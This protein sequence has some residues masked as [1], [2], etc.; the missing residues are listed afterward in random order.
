MEEEVREANAERMSDSEKFSEIGTEREYRYNDNFFKVEQPPNSKEEELYE[1]TEWEEEEIPP[2]LDWEKEAK[3]KISITFEIKEIDD[4][5]TERQ[6]RRRQTIHDLPSY[7]PSGPLA[8]DILKFDM[9]TAEPR[10]KIRYSVSLGVPGI[11]RID[12]SPLTQKIVGCIVGK[13]VTTE[14]P[15]VHV[16]KEVI[17]DNIDLHSESSDFLPVKDEIHAF[18]DEKILIGYAPSLSEKGQF[19][20]V[21]TE[22]GRDIVE[23]YIKMQWEEYADRVKSTIYKILGQW[24]DLGSGA[25]IDDNIVKNTR[26]LFEIEVTSTADLLNAPINLTDRKADDQTN[27]YIELLPSSQQIFE[28]VW[29]KLVSRY[30]QVTPIVQHNEAQ[31]APSIPVNSGYQY[32]YEYETDDLSTYTRERIRSLKDFLKRY[33]NKI[34]DQVLMNSVWDIYTNDYE[35]LVRNAKDTQ[36]PVPIGYEEHQSYYRKIIVDKVINDLCWHPFWTGTAIATYTQHAKGEHLIGPK[37]YDEVFLA[38]NGKNHVLIWSFTD[39]L[40]PKLILECPREVTSVAVCP[41]DATIIVGGCIN[42]Q[43][44]IWHIP[45]KIE[46]VETVVAQTGVQTKYSIAMRSLMTWMYETT[47]TSL[48]SPTAMSSLKYSQK[49]GITQI[50]W[51]PSHHKVDKNGLISSLPEDAPLDDLSCQFATASEDGTVAFWDLKWRP[52]EKD[53]RQIRNRKKKIHSDVQKSMEQSVSPF[54]VLDRVFKPNYILVIQYPDESRQ[55]VIT[56]LSMYNPKFH[57]EQV[58]PFPVARDDLTIRKYY[59]PIIEK[60]DYV[61]EPRMLIGTVEGDFGCITWTGYEFATDMIVNRETARW[62]WIKRAHDG[63][64]THA[65]RSNYYH[66]LVVT[67]GGRIFALWRDDFGEPLVWKRSNV[68]Y[69]ACSWGILRPTFLILGRMDGT[70]EIWDLIVKSHEPSFVQSLSGRIITGIYTHEL[71]LEPQC[72]GFCDFNGSLRIFTAPRVLLTYDVSDVEWLKKFID[73]Q[74]QRISEFQVWQKVWRET[75]LAVIEMKKRLEKMKKERLEVKEKIKADTIEAAAR[76]ITPTKPT[77]RKPWQFLEEA[78][79]RWM[80][81]EVKRMQRLILEKKGLR[82]DV[83][84]RQRAPVLR[85]RQEARTKK[86]KIREILNLQ[87]KIFEET[88]VFLFPEQYQERRETLLPPLPVSAVDRRLTIDEFIKGEIALRKEGVFA[89]AE[90][91]IIYNFLEVQAEALA[92]LKSTPFERTFDWRKVLARGKSRRRSMDIELKKL[93][94]PKKT[95]KVDGAVNDAS[96][97]ASNI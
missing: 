89:D 92:K 23:K 40:S 41:L 17:E 8:N 69:T 88:I 75:N 39:S 6:T 57:K 11:I 96:C 81:M 53:I 97:L 19:Y 42:G 26:P 87:D 10:K 34:C 94:R 82:K 35:N 72:I 50:V 27:G 37:T 56:T 85:L 90:E 25:E 36:A 86:R 55:L 80:S 2:T 93:N 22:Q 70:V 83:I 77:R 48:I 12:L 16:K 95:C 62:L 78:K 91:E 71:P 7:A 68:R 32:L 21:L 64:V 4:M 24:Y 14:Y 15:W 31:T 52:S 49:A 9:I 5:S 74:V 45:G 59:R 60:E 29:R 18:P 30:T 73:R 65:I 43:I 66:R 58:E 28:N 20:I 76:A 67:I 44:A 79:K 63:P 47:A 33:T 38:S 51:L 54:K 84:E 46:Q 1:E 61:M 13:D 3:K